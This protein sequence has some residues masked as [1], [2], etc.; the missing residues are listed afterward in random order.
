MS[1]AYR[2][3]SIWVEMWDVNLWDVR[4]FCKKDYFVV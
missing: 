3:M 2:G 4:L 1:V